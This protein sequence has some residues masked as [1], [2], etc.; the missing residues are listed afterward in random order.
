[1]AVL[2]PMAERPLCIFSHNKRVLFCFLDD[3]F[4]GCTFV[5]EQWNKDISEGVVEERNQSFCLW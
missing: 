3:A 2:S 5:K 1:M 4:C